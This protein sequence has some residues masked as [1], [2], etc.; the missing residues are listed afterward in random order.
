M[1]REL[2]DRD[3]QI[4]MKL[5]PELEEL[6][7]K[8]I[9]LEYRNIL[10]PVANHHSRDENDFERRLSALSDEDMRYLADLVLEG[11]ESTGCLYP[12]FAEVFFALAATRLSSDVAD[13][14]REAYESGLGCEV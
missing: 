2:S 5:V 3:R 14:L 1:A 10:P 13:R 11:T 12:E 6:I 4:L 8:G 7:S 9:E